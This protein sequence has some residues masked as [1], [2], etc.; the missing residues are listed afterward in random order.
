[1]YDKKADNRVIDSK[2]QM[3]ELD[4][5]IDEKKEKIRQIVD[6]EEGLKALNKSISRC[7]EMLSHSIEGNDIDKVLAIT[8]DVNINNTKRIMNIIDEKKNNIKKEIKTIN[9][10]KESIESQKKE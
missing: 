10:E 6:V 2:K 7:I 1:M 5:E 9:I 4:D 3:M 8:N